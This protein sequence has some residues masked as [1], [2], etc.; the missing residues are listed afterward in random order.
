M[1]L[2]PVTGVALMA[3]RGLPFTT[4]WLVLSAVL[5]VAIGACW[6]PVVVL[7]YRLARLACEATSHAAL[8]ADYHRAMRLWV[9]LGVPAFA[10]VLAIYALMVF[11]PAL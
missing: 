8:G 3:E 2:Q 10:M 11:K 4:P 9:A 7:Q 1:V 6:I 5:Y